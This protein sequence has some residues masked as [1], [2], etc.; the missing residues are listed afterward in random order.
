MSMSVNDKARIYRELGKLFAV[1]FPMDKSVAMLLDQHS[2]GARHEFL[3]GID[4]GLSQRLGFAEAMSTYN[5]RITSD[6]ERSLITSGERSGRLAEACEHLA[7]YFETWHKGIREA[8]GAM[9]YPLLLLHVGIIVPEISRFML[10]SQLPGNAG[11]MHLWPAILWRIGLFWVA[12]IVLWQVWRWASRASVKSEAI[13]RCINFLPLIG[14]VRRHWAL[15]RFCQVFHSALLASMR[16]TECL[17]M[18][19]DASQSGIVSN[20]AELAAKE[21]AGGESLAASLVK[22]KRFPRLF[23][24]AV[25]TSEASGVLDIEFARW[26]QA[27]TD[28]AT[29]A[30]RSVAEWYPKALYFLV[31]GYIAARIIGFASDYFGTVMNVDKFM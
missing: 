30:Q 4:R 10:L 25:Q 20:G 1:S 7:H 3:E 22:S 23:T 15:S 29:E 16:I 21:V 8:R 31:L 5:H 6:L 12:L 19:G 13:D 26:A 28:L 24:N 9:V 17:H 27:E 2:S 11:E 14:S 18:A